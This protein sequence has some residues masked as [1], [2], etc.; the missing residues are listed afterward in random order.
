MKKS[1]LRAFA[2][3]LCLCC[4][5]TSALAVE[6][7]ILPVDDP[8]KP[9]RFISNMVAVKDTL[10]IETQDSY[11]DFEIWYWQPGM[12]EALLACDDVVYAISY[13]DI[14]EARDIANGADVEHAI[15][16]LFTDGER[17]CAINAL[18]RRVFA[19]SFADG[20]AEYTDIVTLED[21]DFLYPTEPA[22]KSRKVHQPQ[23]ICV[24]GDHLLIQH[25]W[26]DSANGVRVDQALVCSL[27]D[28]SVRLL[29]MDGVKYVEEYKDGRALL[30][31]V[32]WKKAGSRFAGGYNI[33]SYDPVTD[34][35]YEE[36]AISDATYLPEVVY[37]AATDTLFYQEGR[38]IMGKQD[39]QMPEVY[40]HIPVQ[41]DVDL[42][43]LG[44]TILMKNGDNVDARTLVRNYT[45]E[46]TLAAAVSEN[47]DAQ[48]AFS[49]EHP[50]VDVD[51]RNFNTWDITNDVYTIHTQSEASISHLN[52]QVLLDLSGSDI[53]RDYVENLYPVFRDLA[54][55]DGKIV[56]VPVD[57]LGNSGFFINKQVMQKMGL[58]PED[59][60]TN[61]P[62]LLAFISR[63]NT[64]WVQK[65][66]SYTAFE[67]AS[68]YRSRLLPLIMSLWAGQCQTSGAPLHFDDPAL[69]QV[70]TAFDAMET[71]NLELAMKDPNPEDSDYMQGLIWDG[72]FLVGNFASYMEAY[73]DRVFLPLTLTA[74]APYIVG[75]SDVDLHVVNAQTE[76]PEEAIAF[77]EAEITAMDAKRKAKMQA[78]AEPVP[79]PEYERIVAETEETLQLL[80]SIDSV[81]DVGAYWAI[82]DAIRALENFM[83]EDMLRQQYSISPTALEHYREVIVPAMYVEPPMEPSQ[84]FVEDW[85]KLLDDYAMRKIDMETFIKCLDDMVGVEYEGTTGRPRENG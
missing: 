21:S 75:L 56:A 7:T 31:T 2:F 63:W 20:K 68:N 11:N 28:G 66:P 78:N 6:A 82:R 48:R 60:P 5:F 77:L 3:V 47:S 59:I 8:T 50:N 38:T 13:T 52:S 37:D 58:T 81:H 74:D 65:Y 73:S 44:D 40:A 42:A 71:S 67:Y 64:E 84:D 39:F 62:D 45:P 15:T 29:P 18:N 49:A 12:P 16:E 26:Y 80:N 54:V 69:R 85:Y 36:G 24:A 57:V 46:K 17:L 79:N 4:F 51:Y 35:V 19:I 55:Q 22:R 41:V 43:V 9:Y 1:I 30:V 70:L 72:C 61:M 32:A 34:R 33:Y 83:E 53:I 14:D 25:D 23:S 10:Y 27:K 76:H